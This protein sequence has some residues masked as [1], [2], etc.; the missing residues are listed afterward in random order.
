LKYSQFSTHAGGAYADVSLSFEI[1]YGYSR[2]SHVNAIFGGGSI[3]GFSVNTTVLPLNVA[4]GSEVTFSLNG[5]ALPLYN[6]SIGVDAPGGM[7]VESHSYIGKT[8]KGWF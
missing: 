1:N 6:F 3:T 5:T 7:P 8:T 2:N 4:V